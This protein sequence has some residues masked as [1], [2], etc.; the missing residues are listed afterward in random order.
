MQQSFVCVYLCPRLT[1]VSADYTQSTL[2][3]GG[4]STSSG[5]RRFP[6]VRDRP[7]VFGGRGSDRPRDACADLVW[8]TLS[9]ASSGK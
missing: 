6:L 2:P 5:D 4:T 7:L 1:T 8:K 9:L 3:V